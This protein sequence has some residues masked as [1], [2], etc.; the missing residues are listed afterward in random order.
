MA[1]TFTL[2]FSYKITYVQRDLLYFGLNFLLGCREFPLRLSGG[3]TS[4]GGNDIS[5]K[6]TRT[7]NFSGKVEAAKFTQSNIFDT[8]GI[9]DITREMLFMDSN[10]NK[11]TFRIGSVALKQV[12]EFDSNNIGAINNFFDDQYIELSSFNLQVNIDGDSHSLVARPSTLKFG[13]QYG[14]ILL[15]SWP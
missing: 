10:F 11:D 9:N 7:F 3:S 5:P 2:D 15:F 13:K 8:D 12:I 1:A 4:T 6:S 14:E